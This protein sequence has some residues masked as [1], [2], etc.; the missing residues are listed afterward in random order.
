M[1]IIGFFG[2]ALTQA[3]PSSLKILEDLPSV[4][5]FR[6]EALKDDNGPLYKTQL[7]LVKVNEL[8]VRFSK[9]SCEE[10]RSALV[11]YVK[12][13]EEKVPKLEADGP[14]SAFNDKIRPYDCTKLDF[15]S[16]AAANKVGL[17]KVGIAAEFTKG[18]DWPSV[19][20]TARYHAWGPGIAGMVSLA[21]IIDRKSDWDKALKLVGEGFYD[22]PARRPG[23]SPCGEP[24]PTES[25]PDTIEKLKRLVIGGCFDFSSQTAEAAD[26]TLT[27]KPLQTRQAAP[28]FEDRQRFSQELKNL[29]NSFATQTQVY[30]ALGAP[31]ETWSTKPG[32]R[33]DRSF[34]SGEVTHAWLYGVQEP[35]GL[36]QLGRL[37]FNADGRVIEAVGTN[38]PSAGLKFIPPVKLANSLEAL[39]RGPGLYADSFR[40]KEFSALCNSL[41]EQGKDRALDILQ[42]FYDLTYHNPITLQSVN[43]QF[44]FYIRRHPSKDDRWEGIYLILRGIFDSRSYPTIWPISGFN[45]VS[46]SV[47]AF[48]PT[49]PLLIFRGTPYLVPL[50]LFNFVPGPKPGESVVDHLSFYRQSGKLRKPYGAHSHAL[51]AYEAKRIL[52]RVYHSPASERETTTLV[53]ECYPPLGAP[54]KSH[55][56]PKH[57]LN[58][59]Q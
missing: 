23:P 3:A 46:E 48:D 28:R 37:Y 56:R 9:L 6:W 38:P 1:V 13:C 19:K 49:F 32:E 10:Q 53:Q 22:L 52:L 40:S 59:R 51:T 45:G 29:C 58:G 54:Q 2:L 44:V 11:A 39:Y 34:G 7:E 42:E 55:G 35:G 25:K 15:I 30:A 14:R 41:I 12:E 8:L 21:T 47:K 33:I 16:L 24:V 36:P 31:D 5:Q 4:I 18:D 20:V 26:L 43:G 50:P 27:R 57:P 17:D